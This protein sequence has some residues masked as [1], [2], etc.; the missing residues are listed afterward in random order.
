MR[1]DLATLN[2][3]TLGKVW[4]IYQNTYR[5]VTAEGGCSEYGITGQTMLIKQQKSQGS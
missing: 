2:R 5:N 4:I 1:V 3:K